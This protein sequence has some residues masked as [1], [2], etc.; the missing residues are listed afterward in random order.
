MFLYSSVVLLSRAE[1]K[2]HPQQSQSRGALLQSQ[3][4]ADVLIDHPWVL[5]KRSD[6]KK[7]CVN[8]QMARW[9]KLKAVEV[10]AA[11]STPYLYQCHV[12]W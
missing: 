3:Q 1:V 5:V 12:Q 10:S 6:C 7:T 11:C 8:H 4:G 9:L 2:T